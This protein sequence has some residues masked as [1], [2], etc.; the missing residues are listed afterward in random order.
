MREIPLV[1]VAVLG[2]FLVGLAWGCGTREAL[3]GVTRTRFENGVLTVEVDAW[4]A[5][6]RGLAFWR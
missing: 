4:A 3:P 5:L 6:G 2:G 1:A